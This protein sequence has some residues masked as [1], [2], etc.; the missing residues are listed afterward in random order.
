[1][2]PGK[3]QDPIATGGFASDKYDFLKGG[4]VDLQN[5]RQRADFGLHQRILNSPSR[6]NTRE[7]NHSQAHGRSTLELV[8]GC[9]KKIQRY[10]EQSQLQRMPLNRHLRQLSILAHRTNDQR[11][12]VRGGGLQLTRSNWKDCQRTKVDDVQR[13]KGMI[14]DRKCELDHH[15]NQTLVFVEKCPKGSSADLVRGHIPLM[16]STPRKVLDR[17]EKT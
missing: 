15:T 5:R 16:N 6:L 1:M 11:E 8:V 3:L 14:A 2:C 9:P 7:K 10:D 4:K 12:I 17:F 13:R